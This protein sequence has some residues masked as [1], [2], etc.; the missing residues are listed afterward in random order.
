MRQTYLYTPEAE[1][2]IALLID[3]VRAA[4]P[5]SD[6][7]VPPARVDVA[8]HSLHDLEQWDQ[9]FKA[10]RY[11]Q[12]FRLANLTTAPLKYLGW[13][14]VLHAALCQEPPTKVGGVFGS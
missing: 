6:A 12:R 3:Q 2:H 14:E 10:C 7:R 4:Y 9:T 5:D 11:T 1:R 13:G 8:E